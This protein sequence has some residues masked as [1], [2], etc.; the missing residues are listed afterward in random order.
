MRAPGSGDLQY[1][2]W[3]DRRPPRPPEPR[4]ESCGA[5]F[6]A[7]VQTT[8]PVGLETTSQLLAVAHASCS[9]THHVSRTRLR[10]CHG[11]AAR[12]A[13]PARRIGRGRRT[14]QSSGKGED[15]SSSPETPGRLLSPSHDLHRRWGDACGSVRSPLQITPLPALRSRPAAATRCPARGDD[16]PARLNAVRNANAGLV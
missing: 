7:S 3:T 1:P 11:P 12:L 6:P 8:A 9:G 2:S 14:G 10:R 16:P 15:G 4:S 5:L 13:A